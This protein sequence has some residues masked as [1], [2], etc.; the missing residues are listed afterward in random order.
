MDAIFQVVRRPKGDSG[1]VEVVLK[2]YRGKGQSTKVKALINHLR[3]LYMSREEKRPIKVVVFSQFTSFLD[4]I[5]DELSIE[6]FNLLRFDG[7]MNQKSRADVL[8]TFKQTEDSC[9][10]LL[11]LKAGGVGLNL[12]CANRAYLMDP[13]WSYAVESQ[14]I[15]RIHRMG[16]S[17][18]VQIVRFIVEGSVEERM[19]KIQDRKKFLATTLGLSEEDKR[20][21]RLEDI[22]TLFEM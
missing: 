19:L 15:D 1:E 22:K 14:A 8:E 11:S 10:M 17:S 13:W 9:I 4:K 12:V 18:E 20:A 16:Q 5:Q 2:R 3:P 6:G 21:Q 7:S